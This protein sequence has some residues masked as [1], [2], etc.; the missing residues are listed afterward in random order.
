VVDLRHAVHEMIGQ[1]AAAAEQKGLAITWDMPTSQAPVFTDPVRVRQILGNLLS[2]AVKYTPE[3]G[4]IEVRINERETR[5]E[6]GNGPWIALHVI[7]TGPGIA[8]EDQERIFG[9]FTRL[10]P[11]VAEGA[12]LG[13]SISRRIARLLGG[14]LTVES[15]AGQGSNF[16][17]WLPVR[18]AGRGG[19][20]ETT[21]GEPEPRTAAAD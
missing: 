21:D 14:D 12:G 15:E 2:N 8:P 13:L 7:D 3:G 1:Y 6:G 5:R 4:A 16:T 11:T 20:A 19:T 18:Q 10:A 17:L 9:E